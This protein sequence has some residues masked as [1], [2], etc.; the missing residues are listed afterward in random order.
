MFGNDDTSNNPNP[1]T[2]YNEAGNYT[3]T[4]T[5]ENE[6]ACESSMDIPIYIR[7]LP[8]PNFE[9]VYA[10][11]C[12]PVVVE[13]VNLSE[14]AESYEWSFGDG[15]P[16]STMTNPSHTYNVAG[17]YEVILQAWKDGNMYGYI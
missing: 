14:N 6:F 11:T 7:S 3:I 5:V 1:N 10:D 2:T 4:Q 13:F 17:E 8:V 16:T 9:F 15:T 12:H